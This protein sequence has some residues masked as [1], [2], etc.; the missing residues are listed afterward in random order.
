[1]VWAFNTDYKSSEPLKTLIMLCY[2]M[3]RSTGENGLR[4]L[5]LFIR[6]SF[7]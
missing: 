2:A 5:K 7:L 3:F 1:M 4:T 6:E